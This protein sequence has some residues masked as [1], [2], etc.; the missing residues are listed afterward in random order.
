MSG[1]HPYFD[2]R[3]NQD[4]TAVASTHR[5]HFTSNEIPLSSFLLEAGLFIFIIIKQ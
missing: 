5:P 3:H 2:I 4:I 1:F